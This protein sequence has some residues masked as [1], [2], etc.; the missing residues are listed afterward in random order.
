MSCSDGDCPPNK[1]CFVPSCYGSSCRSVQPVCL[2]VLNASD[3]TW[4]ADGTDSDDK[5]LKVE[6][7]IVNPEELRLL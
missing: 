5:I 3:F 6:F 2:T 4:D 1:E 7:N